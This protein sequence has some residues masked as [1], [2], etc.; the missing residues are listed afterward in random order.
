LVQFVE[1]SN[2]LIIDSHNFI[3][4]KSHNLAQFVELR[5]NLI[6]DSHNFILIKSH[7]LAQFVELSNK[8][9]MKSELDSIR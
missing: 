8:S 4:I 5:D 1:L 6:I 9:E 7:N 3:L 2:N